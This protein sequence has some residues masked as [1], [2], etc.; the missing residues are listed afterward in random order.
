[1][2]ARVITLVIEGQ[3]GDLATISDEIHLVPAL[4]V[5]EA[6]VERVLSL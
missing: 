1:V 2:Q 5:T 6:G 4:E 3:P